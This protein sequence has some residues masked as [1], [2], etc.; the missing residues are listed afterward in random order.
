MGLGM[1]EERDGE[2]ESGTLLGSDYA[3]AVGVAHVGSVK[4]KR[5]VSKSIGARK[6]RCFIS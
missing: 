4:R 6:R 2:S 3:N 5:D 1:I